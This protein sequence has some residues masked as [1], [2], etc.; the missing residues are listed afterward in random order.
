MHVVWTVNVFIG[1]RDFFKDGN[2]A[3]ATFFTIS[4]WGRENTFYAE[5]MGGGQK[6]FAP[7]MKS[8]PGWCAGKFWPLP[9]TTM[10]CFVIENQAF[11]FF[12]RYSLDFGY[13]YRKMS[14]CMKSHLICQMQ[15]ASLM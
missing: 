5:K 13:S 4:D 3:R 15:T 2:G 6:L 10:K 12:L 9:K 1:D 11:A 7:K 14:V 8:F